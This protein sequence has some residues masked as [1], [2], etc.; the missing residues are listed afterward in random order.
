MTV[1]QEDFKP[2]KSERLSL[3]A[4]GTQRALLREASR[5]EGTTVSDFVLRSATRAAE[6]VLSD[7]RVFGLPDERWDAFV[8]VLDR[9]A[10]QLP[11]LRRL[12]E[13]PTVLDE[14]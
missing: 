8:E 7:R 3:R 12:L 10:R 2:A 4:S 1:E 9:P 5:V 11:R 6:D 13:S 14:E